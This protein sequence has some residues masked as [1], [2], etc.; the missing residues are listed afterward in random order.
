MAYRILHGNPSIR[1]SLERGDSRQGVLKTFARPVPN[2]ELAKTR[3][4]GWSRP[5]SDALPAIDG[6]SM[7]RAPVGMEVGE[8]EPVATQVRDHS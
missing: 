7:L 2:R 1:L 3:C 8:A 4:P 6:N 5:R